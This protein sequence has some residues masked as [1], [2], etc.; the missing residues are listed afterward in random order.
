[1][2]GVRSVIHWAVAGVAGRHTI[3]AAPRIAVNEQGMTVLLL[4]VAGEQSLPYH[5]RSRHN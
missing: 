1:M 4:A 2:P 3:N 5:A